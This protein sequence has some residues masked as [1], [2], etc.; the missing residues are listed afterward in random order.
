MRKRLFITLIFVFAGTKS[1][2]DAEANARLYNFGITSCQ[3]SAKLASGY[4]EWLGN[5]KKLVDDDVTIHPEKSGF[6]HKLLTDNNEKSKD[7]LY[8]NFAKIN[9][10]LRASA[11]IRGLVK[12]LSDVVTLQAE[13]LGLN[14]PGKTRAYYQRSLDGFCSETMTSIYSKLPP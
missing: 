9:D 11:D 6:N 14:E 3:A 7:V 8:G 5:L 13:W 1:F 2:A 12:D 4:A 10:A